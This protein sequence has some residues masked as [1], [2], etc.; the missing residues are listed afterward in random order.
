MT[1]D[2]EQPTG[3]V[4]DQLIDVVR[5]TGAPTFVL[6][7]IT[8]DLKCLI[9]AIAPKQE[10]LGFILETKDNKERPNYVG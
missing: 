10:D 1:E 9:K 3:T 8:A 7:E 6:L 5:L 2:E 4:A